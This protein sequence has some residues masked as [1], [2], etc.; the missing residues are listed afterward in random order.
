MTGKKRS[1]YTVLVSGLIGLT[2]CIVFLLIMSMI[3]NTYR[4][5]LLTA[6][7]DFLY[8]NL[9]LIIALSV[10]FMAGE[11]FE[12]FSYPFNLLF[13][14]FNAF[15]SVLLVLFLIRMLE[16]FEIFFTISIS[17][18]IVMLQWIL[19]PLI[20]IVV[21]VTG[22]LSIFKKPPEES[23]DTGSPQ[24]APAGKP[25]SWE[26]VGGEFRQMLYDFFSRIREEIKGK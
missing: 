23:P 10:L 1:A 7:V 19:F 4:L 17:S 24:P 18:A 6:F 22:Y 26:D 11:V 9:V 5:P 13:P 20:F 12:T 3:A 21:I 15:A 16:F 2:L 25:D 14:A 8:A